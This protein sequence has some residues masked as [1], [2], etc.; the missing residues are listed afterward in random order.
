MAGETSCRDQEPEPGIALA[1]ATTDLLERIAAVEVSPQLL[2]DILLGEGDVP[3][4]PPVAPGT[5]RS[6]S[7]AATCA[8]ETV[9][10]HPADVIL[11]AQVRLRA[12]AGVLRDLF[13]DETADTD[14]IL[15]HDN[16]F[17]T[18]ACE[19]L[20]AAPN[21]DIAFDREGWRRRLLRLAEGM[22]R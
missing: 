14:V 5:E 7:P 1:R 22:C 8:A 12:L 10:G 3:P 16:V 13:L 15:L 18:A 6:T 21:D 17:V 2:R 19:P 11:A 9:M 20:I 4:S